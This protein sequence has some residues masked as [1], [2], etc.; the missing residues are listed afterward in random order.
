MTEACENKDDN[1]TEDVNVRHY[2]DQL[3]DMLESGE[4]DPVE[5]AQ[6]LIYWC[7]EDDIKRFMEVRDLI[8]E[9]DD[10]ESDDLA[11]GETIT[12]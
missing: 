3:Y 8:W 1:L 2:S 5:I 11:D 7:S 9:E 6:D 12:Y 10:E 4:V